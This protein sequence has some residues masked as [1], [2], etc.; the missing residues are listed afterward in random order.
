MSDSEDYDCPLCLDE[1]DLADRNFKPCPCGYQICRFCWNHIRV[2]LNGLCPACRRPY[3]E[4]TVEFTPI[5]T[6]E[7]I[8]LKQKKRAKEREKREA[9]AAS[10]RHLQ[11][12][13]VVQ[14]N[15]VYVIGLSPKLANE[16]TLRQPE[17]FG[18]FGKINKMVINRR[19][20]HSSTAGSQAVSYG[21]YITYD[22]KEDA[23]KAIAAVDGSVSDGRTLK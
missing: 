12:M 20:N 8:R 13:R 10:R 6:E 19:L 11:N 18:Q 4:Q 14:K 16:E 5:S 23:A 2:E 15:L 9:D 7:I 17:Y 1:M 22:R 3:S 21:I